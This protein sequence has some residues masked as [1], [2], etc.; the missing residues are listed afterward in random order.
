M[1]GWDSRVDGVNHALLAMVTIRL[2][3][4]RP[5]GLGIVDSDGECRWSSNILRLIRGEA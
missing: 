2:T 5:D 3:A 4:I 1:K